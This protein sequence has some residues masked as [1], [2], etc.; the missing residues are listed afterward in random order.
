MFCVYSHK[1]A[2]VENRPLSQKEKGSRHRDPF[3]LGL[4]QVLD[5]DIC[6]MV[7][8]EQI[9]AARVVGRES[10]QCSAIINIV[11]Q[12]TGKTLYGSVSACITT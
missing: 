5:A 4:N 10:K 1:N 8:S 11:L 6:F 12:L 7:R 2:T 3:F 9:S